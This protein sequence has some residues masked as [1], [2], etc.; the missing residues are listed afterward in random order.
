MSDS[1][2]TYTFTDEDG[3]KI[4]VRRSGNGGVFI[5]LEDAGDGDEVTV[6]VP[7]HEIIHLMQGLTSAVGKNYEM[8]EHEKMPPVEFSGN[9]ITCG[10]YTLAAG[11]DF[12]AVRERSLAHLW[13]AREGERRRA[14]EDAKRKVFVDRYTRDFDGRF[15]GNLEEGSPVWKMLE[16]IEELEAQVKA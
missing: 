10:S 9:Q 6:L 15:S 4:D 8:T 1:K 7:R 11:A 13:M 3:D 5:D 12:T 2:T 16:R 14:T